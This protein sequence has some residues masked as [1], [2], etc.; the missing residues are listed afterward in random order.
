MTGALIGEIIARFEKKG[1]KLVAMK[2]VKPSREHAAAH[3]SD[4]SSKP[5]FPALVDF[6]SSSPVVAMVW[7]GQD[8]CKTIRN[9]LGQTDPAKSA[10]GSIRGDYCIE[11]GRNII[12]ASD[13]PSAGQ[14]EIALWFK[15]GV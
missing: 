8:A 14:E 11:M 6:F 3:Y 2:L 13:S 12:H 10:P 1:F 9:M 5:F 15:E 7:E 4:L